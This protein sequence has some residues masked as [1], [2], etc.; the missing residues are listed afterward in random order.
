MRFDWAS[1][2]IVPAVLTN[3]TDPTPITVSF[4]IPSA[5]DP[6]V[7]LVGVDPSIYVVSH[8]GLSRTAKVIGTVA[9]HNSSDKYGIDRGGTLS[10][11]T[12]ILSFIPTNHCQA[13]LPDYAV[14]YL[15]L[16]T[17]TI[18]DGVFPGYYSNGFA[19]NSKTQ[20]LYVADDCLAAI[21]AYRYNSTDKTFCKPIIFSILT[22]NKLY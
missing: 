16:T 10:D 17:K 14:G 6:D 5:S 21:L 18:K 4:T 8:V 12:V 19:F 20:V 2:T 15:D 22:N 1:K 13:G 3:G 11:G 9:S 7:L